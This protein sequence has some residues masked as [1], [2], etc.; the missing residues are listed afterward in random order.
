MPVGIIVNAR[1]AIACTMATRSNHM[2]GVDP[3]MYRHFAI[4]TIAVTV[5]VAIFSGDNTQPVVSSSQQPVEMPKSGEITVGGT[6]LV[7]NRDESTKQRSSGSGFDVD[8]GSFTDLDRPGY[9]TGGTAST[10]GNDKMTVIIEPNEAEMANM[11]SKQRDAY[12]ANLN[13]TA[14]RLA[15]K[16]PYI[17]TDDQIAALAT[18][19]AAR[20]GSPATD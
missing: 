20:A 17:P 1:S 12:L 18:E 7:D 19:S 9:G 11:V 13:D 14:E 10:I 16:G 15:A 4:G 2:L 3:K 8:A 5:I 6:K